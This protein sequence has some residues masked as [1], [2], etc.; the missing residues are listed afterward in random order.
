MG[1]PGRSGK[2]GIMGPRGFKGEH[3]MKGQKGD[4]GPNG[5]PGMKGEPGESI[6]PPAVVVSPSTLTVNENE[7]ASFQ[8]S[9]SGNPQPVVEWS[10]NDSA[11]NPKTVTSSGKIL[12]RNVAGNDSGVYTC[13]ARNILGE[14]RGSARLTINGNREDMYFKNLIYPF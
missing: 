10:R 3:G 13:A 4:L 14:A 5:I 8:C 6:S 2:Q 11:M 7:V 9:A 12:W 1:S